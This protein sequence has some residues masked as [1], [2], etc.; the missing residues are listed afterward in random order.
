M[1]QY[2][3]Q[4]CRAPGQKVSKFSP[5]GEEDDATAST[6]LILRSSFYLR[7]IRDVLTK[8]EKQHWLKQTMVHNT[9][10]KYDSIFKYFVR[11]PLQGMQGICC[12]VSVFLIRPTPMHNISFKVI[13]KILIFRFADPIFDKPVSVLPRF[14]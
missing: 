7:I 13:L 8:L 11:F 10:A 9:I 12:N 4:F 3:L 5:I 14:F 2:I 1:L 6:T